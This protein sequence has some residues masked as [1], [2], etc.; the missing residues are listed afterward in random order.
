MHR[1]F[2][3]MPSRSLTSV[4]S[5]FAVLLI[6]AVLSA[7]DNGDTATLNDQANTATFGEYIVRFNLVPAAGL[8]PAMADKYDVE[9]TE[10]TYVL[11]VSVHDLDAG[12]T[13]APL[14]ATI[15]A[16]VANANA[17]LITVPITAVVANDNVTYHGSVEVHEA[18]SLKFTLD[19]QPHGADEPFK[20][21]FERDF[22]LR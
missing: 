18:T 22:A 15:H 5:A 17:Q 2:S 3:V 4:I 10:D 1:C 6:A 14:P 11:N 13:G 12:L 21:D 19:V 20:L 8:T 9:P 7:C 16:T